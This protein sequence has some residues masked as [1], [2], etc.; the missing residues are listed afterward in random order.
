[1]LMKRR[2]Q[3]RNWRVEW[4]PTNRH[5]W[6]YSRLGKDSRVWTLFWFNLAVYQIGTR[7]VTV[8]WQEQNGTRLFILT[9]NE[10]E[11]RALYAD[12]GRWL[13]TSGEHP[14]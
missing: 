12:L 6:H 4:W 7:T 10:D 13:E 8:M 9:L 3:W 2:W 14:I 5:R 1:M 11:A